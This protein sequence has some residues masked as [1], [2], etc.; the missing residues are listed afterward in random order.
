MSAK[1]C[2]RAQK[3]AQ[4]CEKKELEHKTSGE[5]RKGKRNGAEQKALH[6]PGGAC[7]CGKQRTCGRGFSE[8]WQRKELAANFS[9]LWQA[10][11]LAGRD[12][13]T[14]CARSGLASLSDARFSDVWQTEG[15]Q[16]EKVESQKLKVQ[17]LRK[18]RGKSRLPQ[19]RRVHR[20]Q[21]EA[22]KQIGAAGIAAS[23]TEDSMAVTPC[24]E[25]LIS[26]SNARSIGMTK[27]GELQRLKGLREGCDSNDLWK[28]SLMGVVT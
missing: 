9:D 20:D 16:E 5:R 11:S 23:L 8:V 18:P 13:S 15:L 6:N 21:L 17:S 19:R 1:Q 22:A 28:T 24:Q 2:K 25:L 12:P 14:R 3:S 26:D 7:K 27:A 10:K 4:E